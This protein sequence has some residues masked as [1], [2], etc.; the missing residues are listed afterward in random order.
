MPI[1]TRDVSTDINNLR[2]SITALE[3]IKLVLVSKICYIHCTCN[4]NYY[5]HCI[6]YFNVLT[7][8][9]VLL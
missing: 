2:E 5:N 4:N 7:I 8:T 9:S 6:N 1:Q 3:T